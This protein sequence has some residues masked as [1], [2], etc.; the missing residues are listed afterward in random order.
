MWYNLAAAKESELGRKNRDIT[1][2]K[3]TAADISKAQRLARE[4]FEKHGE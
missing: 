3:M 4:W 2:K 1:A